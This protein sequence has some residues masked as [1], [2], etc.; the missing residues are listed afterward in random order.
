MFR[1]VVVTITMAVL[2]SCGAASNKGLMPEL[3]NCDSA[4][5]LYYHTPGDPRFFNMTKV[6][7][8]DSLSG[9][10][11]NVNSKTIKPKDS[12]ITQGKIYFYGKGEVVYPVYFSRKEDCMTFSFIITGKK[13][14]S[15]MSKSSRDI[16]NELEK[17]V[18]VF[19]GRKE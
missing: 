11:K 7:K 4:V 2:F 12:C 13:Y 18:K 14:F 8:M 16:L 3:A 1:F 9:V 10:I 5:V 19:E 17:R 15:S 6:K